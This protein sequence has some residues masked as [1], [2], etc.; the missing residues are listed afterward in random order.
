MGWVRQYWTVREETEKLRVATWPVT[1]PVT[2]AL[3]SKQILYDSV[4]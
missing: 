1:W 2:W 4:F 3:L